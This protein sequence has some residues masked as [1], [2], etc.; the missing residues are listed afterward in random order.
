MAGA[1]YDPGYSKEHWDL[2]LK[3]LGPMD[4]WSFWDGS[5]YHDYLSPLWISRDGVTWERQEA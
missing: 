1:T 5:D 4:R 2:L 3:W